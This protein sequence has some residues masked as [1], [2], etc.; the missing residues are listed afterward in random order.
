M[1]LEKVFLP[2]LFLYLVKNF[3]QLDCHFVNTF[4]KFSYGGTMLTNYE[5]TG[6]LFN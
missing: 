5:Q 2:F 1:K 3:N 6:T 4:L